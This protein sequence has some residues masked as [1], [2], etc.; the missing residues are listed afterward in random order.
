MMINLTDSV[1]EQEVAMRLFFCNFLFDMS[2]KNMAIF[3]VSVPTANLPHLKSVQCNISPINRS[4]KVSW[5]ILAINLCI[6]FVCPT[7]FGSNIS[8]QVVHGMIY[9]SHNF[10]VAWTKSNC[11]ITY[12][13]L[14]S[15]RSLKLGQKGDWWTFMWLGKSPFDM[16]NHVQVKVPTHIGITMLDGFGHL[17]R[18]HRDNLAPNYILLMGEGCAVWGPGKHAQP[19]G[20]GYYWLCMVDSQEVT[21]AAAAAAQATCPVTAI[22]SHMRALAII[23]F[24]VTGWPCKPWGDNTPW[25]PLWP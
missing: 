25:Q 5:H 9:S 10:V 17:M 13:L 6:G 1:G 15:Q 19:L 18:K 16:T 2:D 7:L 21:A 22:F 11:Q 12:N 24:I 4:L 20:V 8:G 14:G 23:R 3:I